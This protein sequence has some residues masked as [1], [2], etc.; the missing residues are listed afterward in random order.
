LILHKIPKSV[1]KNCTIYTDG[2]WSQQTLPYESIFH[3]ERPQDIKATAA[4]VI[5]PNDPAWKDNVYTILI[6]DLP[7]NDDTIHNPADSAFTME[8]LALAATL[9]LVSTTPSRPEIK[10]DCLSAIKLLAKPNKLRKYAN[11]PQL[12]ILQ[13]AIHFQSLLHPR[14]RIS[15]VPAH[16][17]N[18]TAPA[19]WKM[20]IWGNHIADRV[21]ASDYDDLLA[22]GIHGTSFRCSVKDVLDSFAISP[23]WFHLDS[24]TGTLRVHSIHNIIQ[25]KRQDEYLTTRDTYHPTRPTPPAMQLPYFMPPQSPSPAASHGK[26]SATTRVR[27]AVT[28][29]KVL[30]RKYL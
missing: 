15:H 19:N 1:L 3:K 7:L 4:I 6:E 18:K 11:K 25:L 16:T 17:G 22:K 20:D 21:A 28:N 12:M 9:L 14:P 2:S 30:A 27:L 26:E 5:I 29:S 8:V 10:S 13:S 24:A 23:G